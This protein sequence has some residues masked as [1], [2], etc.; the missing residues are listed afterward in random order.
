[1]KLLCIT[2]CCDRPE[3]ELFIGL[4]KKGVN[5]HVMCNPSGRNYPRLQD[6]GLTLFE[7]QL[8][9]RFDPA[10]IRRIRTLAR[11]QQYDII[12]TFDNR[13]LQNTVLATTGLE[14][15]IVA[16]R[17]IVGN[18][19]AFDPASWLTYLHPKVKKI[20]CVANAIRDHFLNMPLSRLVLPPDKPVTVYKGHSLAWYQEAPVDLK[21]FGVPEE[22]FVVVFTG[23]DRP[24]KGVRFLIEAA[25]YLPEEAP[26][27]FLLVG[28]MENNPRLRKLI[29]N[30]PDPHRFHFAGYRNDAPAIA[31]AASTLV[32][33]SIYGEGLPRSVI[34][35]MAY[36]TPP[37]V[38]NAGGSPELVIDGENGLIVPPAD[39]R[40]IAAAIMQLYANPQR[41]KQMGIN[42]RQHIDKN[43]NTAQTI[44]Q[45]LTIYHQLLK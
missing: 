30:S 11:S 35:A 25:H 26:I 40:A 23:R 20:T 2:D 6:A 44:E 22:A 31:A 15:P 28:P 3:S 39:G 38:A 41:R 42:A 19:S 13:A 4:S 1:M 43:F 12:Q 45:M 24:R 34:E 14:I 33:P 18:V 29:D 8:K 10:G 37:I 21:M 7:S 17:G 9:G 32:M 27:H 16:Y 36:G 5:I